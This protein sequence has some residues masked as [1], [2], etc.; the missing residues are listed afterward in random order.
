MFEVKSYPAELQVSCLKKGSN[1]VD[2]ATF[3]SGGTTK[4][5]TTKPVGFGGRV[6]MVTT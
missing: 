4:T 3:G 6:A 2:F 1:R 5:V